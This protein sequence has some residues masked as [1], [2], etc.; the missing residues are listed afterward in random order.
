[1]HICFNLNELFELKD[2]PRR[3]ISVALRIED[4]LKEQLKKAQLIQSPEAVFIQQQIDFLVE[5][6]NLLKEKEQLII[7]V[8][9]VLYDSVKK[10]NSEIMDIMKML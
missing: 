7:N 3:E 5:E 4:A 10:S 2:Y 1:M 9:N 6:I 8:H